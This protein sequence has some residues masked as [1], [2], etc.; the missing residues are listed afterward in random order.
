MNFNILLIK[1]IDNIM[2]MTTQFDSL[3]SQVLDEKSSTDKVKNI[4]EITSLYI[5]IRAEHGGIII[6][7]DKLRSKIIKQDNT[8]SYETINRLYDLST[9]TSIIANIE[10]LVNNIDFE[11]KKIALM[12][13]ELIE[14]KQ[15]DVVLFTKTLDKD[16]KY[17]K[18]IEEVKR[19]NKQ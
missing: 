5:L 19:I 10:N 6:L 11:Y 3:C 13:P 12:F 15:L 18:L 2:E 1:K 8:L 16:D 17:V 7:N 14:K 4:F 9:F